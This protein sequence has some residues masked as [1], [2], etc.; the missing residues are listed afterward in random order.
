MNNLLYILTETNEAPHF[1]DELAIWIAVGCF[2]V[3]IFVLT[4]VVCIKTLVKAIK[5]NNAAKVRLSNANNEH[6]ELFGGNDNIISIKKEM[7]RVAV[8]VKD[9]DLVNLDGLKA[10]QIGVL[11]MGNTVKCSSKELVESLEEK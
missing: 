3:P 4:M 7:T 2:F 11:I 1:M 10:L 5:K 6:Y 9:L 8:E